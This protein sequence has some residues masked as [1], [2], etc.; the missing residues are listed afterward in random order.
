MQLD[1]FDEQRDTDEAQISG[2]DGV[3]LSSHVDVFYAILRQVGGGSGGG[4][5]S[6]YSVLGGLEADVWMRCVSMGGGMGCVW[7]LWVDECWSVCVCVCC[8]W[9]FEKRL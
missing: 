8:F 9:L 3:D 6:P 1:V 5:G 4:G 7:V 2:P